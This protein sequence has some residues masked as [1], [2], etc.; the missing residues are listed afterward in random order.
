[1]NLWIV[2]SVSDESTA[3]IFKVGLNP[4]YG[5]DIFLPNIVNRLQHVVKT[6]KTAFAKNGYEKEVQTFTK[7]SPL[8]SLF[9]F[10]FYVWHCGT[11]VPLHT[12]AQTP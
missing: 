10:G 9:F 11:V 1:V 2:T 6:Q 7:L 12:E 3:Y 5:S 4:E 8:M